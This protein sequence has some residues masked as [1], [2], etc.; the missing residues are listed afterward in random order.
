MDY[1]AIADK[2]GKSV[3]TVQRHFDKL[4]LRWMFGKLDSQHINLCLDGVYFGQSVC[5]I[6]LRA[7]RGKHGQN[8]Y[9]R[10]CSETVAHVREC[11]EETD[12][13]GYTYKSFTIDGRPGI[14]KML[15]QNYPGIP[16][17]YCQFHQKKTIRKYLTKEPKTEFGQA[18]LKFL[19]PITQYTKEEFK[20]G[21]E[22]LET[23]YKAFLEERNENNRYKHKRLRSAFR[24][25]K[26]NM[27]YLF[28]YREPEYIHLNIPNTTN[29]CE[30]YFTHLKSRVHAHPGL[31]LPR[32]QKLVNRLLYEQHK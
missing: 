11:I 5:Y 24:S 26:R 7:Q 15:E 12:S 29:T 2:Y 17:Q 22:A 30:G 31:T 27:P 9:F 18:L 19:R 13:R 1:K 20:V 28:T 8:I 32:K 10:Q 16:I 21:L 25:L 23:R 4:K 14:I 6:V 3:R